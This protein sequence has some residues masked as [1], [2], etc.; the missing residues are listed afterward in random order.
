MLA[1]G[2][3]FPS[4]LLSVG[5]TVVGAGPPGHC[6]LLILP[7]G[8]CH[9]PFRNIL[10]VQIEKRKDKGARGKETLGIGVVARSEEQR[11]DR[12]FLSRWPWSCM[13]LDEAHA[14]KNASAARTVRLNRQALSPTLPCQ[15][16][17]ACVAGRGGWEGCAARGAR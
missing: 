5:V 11:L 1:H 13:V 4:A 16:E 8:A 9:F 15:P 3:T 2:L 12:K 17:R 14:V 6:V 10:N 7:M